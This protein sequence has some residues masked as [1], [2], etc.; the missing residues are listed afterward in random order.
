VLALAAIAGGAAAATTGLVL[1]A[2]R[3]LRSSFAY[4]TLAGVLVPMTFAA[5]IAVELKI[6][7]IT[8]CDHS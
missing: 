3:D 5:Y 8:S 6:C 7:A 4:G 2:R 1:L